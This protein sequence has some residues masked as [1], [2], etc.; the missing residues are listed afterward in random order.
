MHS[1]LTIHTANA[2]TN[3]R[4]AARRNRRWSQGR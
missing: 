2:V 1:L 3:E 4:L